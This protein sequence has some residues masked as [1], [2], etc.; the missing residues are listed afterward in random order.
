MKLAVAVDHKGD[1]L[2][3]FSIIN[4]K[5][6]EPHEFF[7]DSKNNN[8][9]ADCLSLKNYELHENDCLETK[10]EFLCEDSEAARK[11]QT[12]KAPKKTSVPRSVLK[13][14]FNYLGDYGKDF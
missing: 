2:D 14:F 5:L 12:T 8:S 1:V 9:A 3:L 7:V 13:R 4:E 6:S 10:L 11:F